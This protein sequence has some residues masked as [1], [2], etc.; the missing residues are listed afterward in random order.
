MTWTFNYLFISTKCPEKR[1]IADTFTVKLRLVILLMLWF[2]SVRLGLILSSDTYISTLMTRL[3][4][5][6]SY[7]SFTPAMQ[8]CL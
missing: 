8:T 3:K 1:L 6:P 4:K 2:V 7:F 5:T